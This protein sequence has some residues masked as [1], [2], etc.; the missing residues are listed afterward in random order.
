M[1]C[2]DAM[3]ELVAHVAK[4]A[5]LSADL[6]LKHQEAVFTVNILNYV[7]LCR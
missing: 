3:L 7:I 4:C 2:K 6:A 5:C 1:L